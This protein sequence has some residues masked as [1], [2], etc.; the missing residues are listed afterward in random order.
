MKNYGPQKK[1]FQFF[2]SLFASSGR[3]GGRGVGEWNGREAYLASIGV[4]SRICL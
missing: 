3:G 1:T 2:P 4:R